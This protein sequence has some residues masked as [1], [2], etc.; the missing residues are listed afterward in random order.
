M[1]S[2]RTPEVRRRPGFKFIFLGACSA[3]TNSYRKRDD[4]PDNWCFRCCYAI[5][6]QYERRYG[7]HNKRWEKR[8]FQWID[9]RFV[10]RQSQM[11]GMLIMVSMS[12]IHNLPCWIRLMWQYISLQFNQKLVHSNFLKIIRILLN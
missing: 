12:F 4:R 11:A 10:C 1:A 5:C 6:F 7:R 3:L 9:S 8:A 2:L